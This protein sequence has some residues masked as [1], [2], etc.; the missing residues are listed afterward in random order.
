[1]AI[2]V[3][4]KTNPS[5]TVRPQVPVLGAHSVSVAFSVW[6]A[7]PASVMA[8]DGGGPQDRPY[9]AVSVGD[10]LTYVYDRDALFSHVN[11]WR[12]AV[13][14]AASVLLPRSGSPPGRTRSGRAR[15]C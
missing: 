7:Q 6:G 4:T 3:D 12:E 13:R 5:S 10:C 14:Q 2:N 8:R 1:M 15:R 11:A 9:L